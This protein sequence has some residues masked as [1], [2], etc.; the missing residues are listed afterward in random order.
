MPIQPIP[1]LSLFPPPRIRA[2]IATLRDQQNCSMNI[3]GAFLGPLF[4]IVTPKVIRSGFPRTWDR[5]SKRT[6]ASNDMI[7][8]ITLFD[9]KGRCAMIPKCLP[10][11]NRRQRKPQHAAK[12]DRRRHIQRRFLT[13]MTF[14]QHCSLLLIVKVIP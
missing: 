2:V 10:A 4:G 3:H 8:L 9:S 7:E 12:E 5:L 14:V 11:P 13:L 6:F 1:T